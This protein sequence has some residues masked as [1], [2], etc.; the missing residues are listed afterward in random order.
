MAKRDPINPTDDEARA[1][2]ARLL[3]KARHAALA[4]LDPETGHP[5]VTRVAILWHDGAAHTL[6][7]DLSAH[8]TALKAD[9]RASL[10]IGEPGTKGDPLTH[11]RLT[12]M[13]RAEEANKAALREIWLGAHPKSQLYYN[14]ADFRMLRLMP[15]SAALN[16]GFGKAYA[17]TPDDLPR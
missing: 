16:G 14:F 6:V 13:V 4:V 10:L 3:T 17:L 2:A 5:S 15:I 8:T 1:L 12:L 7:S 11:P 9:P